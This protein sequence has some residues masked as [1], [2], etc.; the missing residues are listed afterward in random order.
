MN[1]EI[2]TRKPRGESYDTPILFVHGAWHGARHWD[3]HFLPYFAEQ[4]FEAHALNFRNHGKSES[5]GQL[6]WRRG[7][8]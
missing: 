5:T 7:A 6:R 2:I 3:E 1:L 4:G 8:H